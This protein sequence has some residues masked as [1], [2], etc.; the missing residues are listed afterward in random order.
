MLGILPGSNHVLVSHAQEVPLL[1]GQLSPGLGDRLHRGGHV[2][3]A[4]GLQGSVFMNYA[5]FKEGV[6]LL[7]VYYTCSAS[8]AL[9]TSS[10]F[11]VM[12]PVC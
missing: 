12:V 10:S 7:G 9:C 11:S 5:H 6:M 4:L 3:I 2:V 8:L 1:V